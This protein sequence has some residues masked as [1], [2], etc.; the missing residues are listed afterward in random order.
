MDVVLERDAAELGNMIRRWRMVRGLP[1]ATLADRAGIALSTLRMIE[2]GK[3]DRVRLGALLS[4]LRVLGIERLFF[5]AIEPLNTEIGRLRA[6][7]MNRRRA[8]R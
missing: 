4:I 5:D 8:P 7:E 6:S 1:A 3:G 2:Q